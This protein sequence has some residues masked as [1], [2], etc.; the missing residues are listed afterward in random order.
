MKGHTPYTT[1]VEGTGS[2]INVQCGF[3]PSYVQVINIDGD[4]MLYWTKDMT[5]DEGYKVIA[6]GTG[7]QI[8]SGGITPY[9]GTAGANSAGFTIGT[10]TDVNVSA[11][12]L[13]IVAFGGE[14]V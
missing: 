10:D 14:D 7:A 9:A 8:A 1:T 12:T 5:D 4:A 3:S 11:E 6:A 2:A 13:M